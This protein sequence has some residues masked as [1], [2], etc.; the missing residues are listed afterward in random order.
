MTP[1]SI[2]NLYRQPGLRRAH[3]RLDDRDCRAAI[4]PGHGWRSA[5]EDIV[6]KGLCL[7]VERLEPH[8]VERTVDEVDRRLLP[9]G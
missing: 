5:I 4:G 9:D 8:R 2:S 3:R 1:I 6:D 7:C